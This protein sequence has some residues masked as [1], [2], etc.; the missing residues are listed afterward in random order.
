MSVNTDPLNM[1]VAL[2]LISEKVRFW[3]DEQKGV[4]GEVLPPRCMNPGRLAE[5]RQSLIE[6]DQHCKSVLKGS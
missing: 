6:I 4:G 2:T 3:S 1:K 5:L